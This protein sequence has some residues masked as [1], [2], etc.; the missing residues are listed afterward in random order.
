MDKTIRIQIKNR[1]RF[2]RQFELQTD[3]S[4][5]FL[6]LGFG[7]TKTFAGRLTQNGV[8]LYRPRVGLLS[9]FALTAFCSIRREKGEDVLTVR[10]GRCVPVAL[11]WVLWCLLM[12]LAGLFLFEI[13]WILP[14]FFLIPGIGWALPLF[15]FS[16]KER[17]RLL[18]FL[19]SLALL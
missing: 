1:G 7:K 5:P 9:L 15:L 10:F 19:K 13:G 16:K 14:L 17:E 11:I 6:R 3:K 18:S 12:I 2:L 8:L 4:N